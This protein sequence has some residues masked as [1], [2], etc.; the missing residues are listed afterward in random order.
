MQRDERWC[1]RD[2]RGLDTGHARYD[3]YQIGSDINQAW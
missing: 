2:S 3:I 1:G